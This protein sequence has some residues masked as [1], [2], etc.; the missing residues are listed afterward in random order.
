LIDQKYLLVIMIPYHVDGEGARSVDE[1][2][3][4]DLVKHLDHIRD[5]TLAA[6]AR[7]GPAPEGLIP[8]D[9]AAYPGTLRYLD[10]P[11][12]R[13]TLGALAGV[14]SAAYR[15]WKAIGRADVVHV[16]AGGWPISYG[17]LAAPIARARGK[18][19]LTNIESAGWRLGLRR[20]WRFKGVVQGLVFEA[21]ARLCVNL[22]DLA[23]FTHAGYRAGMLIRSR[24]GRGHVIPASWIDEGV[25]LPRAEAER[26]WA[27]KLADGGRPLRVAFAAS[28]LPSKGVRTLLD[29]LDLLEARG[30]PADVR[31]YGKGVLYD[32][33]AAAAGR[34]GRSVTLTLEGTLAYGP[35]FFA[36][37]RGQD[38]MVVPS[39]SDE[40]PRIVYDCYSQ[41]LP[42][43][44]S[45]TPGLRQCVTDGRDGVIVPPGDATALADA[46]EAAAADRARLRDLGIAGLDVARALTHGR[47]H[48]RRAELIESAYRDRQ[49]RPGGDARAGQPAP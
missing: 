18:F 44:A 24:Q 6:P 8:L 27:S 49:A 32:D 19:I 45:D 38:V 29:A 34:L 35:D 37:L 30:V 11:A 10:M 3:H 28:L 20:P 21:M 25:I 9:P 1:L 47:M 40:Q 23:T 26:L 43:V 16:N 7:H 17:W 31:V 41:A 2:W 12:S 36:M 22:A 46:L 15:L 42:V 39:V 4:K 48:S 13:T 33:C 5:L 14:P